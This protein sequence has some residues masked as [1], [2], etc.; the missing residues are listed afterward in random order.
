MADP[1]IRITVRMRVQPGQAEAFKTMARDLTAS[2][3]AE[4]PGTRRLVV[5]GTSPVGS[6][7]RGRWAPRRAPCRLPQPRCGGVGEL[8]LRR[9]QRR[10]LGGAQL[11][12]GLQRGLQLLG[13]VD[14]LVGEV[15]DRMELTLVANAWEQAGR[16]VPHSPGNP[17]AR[18][19][20]PPD[21]AGCRSRAPTPSPVARRYDRG[22]RRQWSGEP[23][24]PR[25][26]TIARLR[27]DMARL[28][29][30]ARRMPASRRGEPLDGAWAVQDLL[31][32][33]AAW[34]RALCRGVDAVL[35]GA[36]PPWAGTRV[37][38]FNADAVTAA[39]GRPFA[40]VLADVEAAHEALLARLETLT[41]DEWERVASLFSYRYKQASHYAGHA[42]E[43][44]TAL[45]RRT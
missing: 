43:I 29:A 26:E 37:A 8:L 20:L 31:A 19:S 4:E 40:D 28:V 42:A 24:D 30:A 34:D 5:A 45:A 9:G 27:A 10:P 15:A 2:V 13:P 21:C 33:I 16:F 41:A 1:S 6:S 14:Q 38:R 35:A 32:H 22:E 7:T 39:R 11:A 18:R 36:R 25:D 44:E 3:E 23:V 12:P 17:R